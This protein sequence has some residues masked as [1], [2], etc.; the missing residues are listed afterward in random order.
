[1]TLPLNHGPTTPAGKSPTGVNFV[2]G[3][4][5]G[6]ARWRSAGAI[7]GSGGMQQQQAVSMGTIRERRKAMRGDMSDLPLELR[8]FFYGRFS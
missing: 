2:A 5:S 1:M 3:F 8:T 6:L 4:A 7:A